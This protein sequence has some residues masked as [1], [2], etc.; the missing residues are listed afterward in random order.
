M[1]INFRKFA[2]IPMLFALAACMQPARLSGDD[3]RV[4]TKNGAFLGTM[5]GAAVGLVSADNSD[6]RPGKVVKAAIIGAGLGALAGT[7]LDRQE[8][9]LRRDLD[10]RD[11]QITN[12]GTVWL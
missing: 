6:E 2:L 1:I 12:T 9:D 7:L 4:H 10:N 3:Q 5:M 8:A 11:V